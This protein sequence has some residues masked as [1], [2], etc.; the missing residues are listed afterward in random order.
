MSYNYLIILALIQ[1]LTEFLPVS[2][3]AHLAVLPRLTGQPDQGL[4]I[5]V[6]VHIGTLAAVML[7]FATEVKHITH[8]AVDIAR[9]RRKRKTQRWLLRCLSLLSPLLSRGLF[10]K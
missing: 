5:D 9:G 4:L 7:T 2:S 6:A 10:C 8:G 3:S 1:G